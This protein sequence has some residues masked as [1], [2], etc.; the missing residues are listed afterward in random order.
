MRSEDVDGTRGR[1]NKRE[2]F[3]RIERQQRHVLYLKR[4]E[5]QEKRRKDPEKLKRN[6]QKRKREIKSGLVKIYKRNK[7]E[8]F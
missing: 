5:T 4:K 1:D 6:E 8:K 2:R 3:V 7:A